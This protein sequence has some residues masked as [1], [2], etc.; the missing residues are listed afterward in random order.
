MALSDPLGIIA[1]PL[2]VIDRSLGEEAAL[3]ELAGIISRNQ[4]GQVIAGL[5]LS[6]SGEEGIQAGRVRAFVREMCRHI[7]VPVDF[8]DERLSTVSARRL[9]RAA[10]KSSRTP[11]DAIAA[12]IILQGYL[13]ESI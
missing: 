8:R 3:V 2:T 7:D 6:M 11:D 4:V 13:E 10:G 1:S 9:M 5:P 12:A